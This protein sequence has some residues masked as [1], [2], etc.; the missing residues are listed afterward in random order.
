M[1]EL[2]K[3][4]AAYIFEKNTDGLWSET[5]KLVA[6]DRNAED[7]FGTS[8]AIYGEYAIVGA[9]KRD[10]TINGVFLRQCGAAY[11]FKK[12]GTGQWEEVQKLLADDPDSLDYFGVSVD[13]FGDYAL[14]GASY[15]ASGS[16]PQ[17]GAVYVFEKQPDGHW[18]EVQKLLAS[19]K[20]AFDLFGWSVSLH[21]N[22]ALIGA[23][24]QDR[25]Q[26]GAELKNNAGA[27]Y[28]FEKNSSGQWEQIQKIVANDRSEGDFFGFDVSME[29]NTLVVGA[30]QSKTDASG[31]VPVN[32]AGAAYIFE[33]NN[34]GIWEQVKK[35]TAT[36][37]NDEDLF[38]YSVAVSGNNVLVG[39]Y[40][41][42]EDGDEQNT[43]N[44]AGAAF[45]FSNENGEWVLNRKLVAA[46]RSPGDWFG[47]SL[48]LDGAEAIIGAFADRDDENS[49]NPLPEAGSAYFFH[50]DDQLD[51]THQRAGFSIRVFPN[52]FSSN[53]SIEDVPRGAVVHIMDEQGR[54]LKEVEADGSD[55]LVDA[56]D[57][58]PGCY[59][60]W[61]SISGGSV[62]QTVIK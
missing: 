59:F 54:I 15:K 49:Q 13:I 5:A 3:A 11:I 16:F 44:G 1:N 7:N 57:F 48:A 24:N 8:V 20:N 35:V 41:E 53:I 19:D 51:H 37:R 34:S 29:E 25:N 28:I 42:D 9:Y 46:D 18:V 38:G 60:V 33:K 2:P 12:N 32:N 52:P 55:L 45:L 58:S 36:E 62:V 4:G 22:Q 40:L 17:A 27:A 56:A 10:E 26:F 31:A 39:A 21:G 61:V 47:F 14:V 6:S 23:Y 30:Y 43:M 50:N